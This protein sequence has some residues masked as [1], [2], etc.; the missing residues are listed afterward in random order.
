MKRELAAAGVLAAGAALVGLGVAS[1]YGVL[2]EYADVCG[3]TPVVEQ[4]WVDGAGLGPLV[5]A[6]A[7]GA[8]AIVLALSR[9]QLLRAAAAGLVVTALVG[10]TAAGAIGIAGKRAAFDH[11]P[12]Q[13]GGCAGYNSWSPTPA[14]STALS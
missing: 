1:T 11:R 4:V 10:A 12:T 14:P 2:R 9:R 7:L 13:Y 3:A 6:V 8:A 5:A